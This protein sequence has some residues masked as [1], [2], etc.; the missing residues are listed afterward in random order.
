MSDIGVGD[1]ISGKV[2]HSKDDGG[3]VEMSF[4]FET[5]TAESSAKESIHM[6]RRSGR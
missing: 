6:S 2:R 5:R 4:A 1:T 3:Q